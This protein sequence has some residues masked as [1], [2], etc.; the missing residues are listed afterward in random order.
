MTFGRLWAA[1]ICG[2]TALLF[3]LPVHSSPVSVFTYLPVS[4]VEN[5]VVQFDGSGSFDTVPT[6]SITLRV[7]DFG[8]NTPPAAAA[9]PLAQHTY[10]VAGA[11]TVGLTVLDEPGLIG[12]SSQTIVV[13]AATTPIPAALPLFA[14]GSGALGFVRLAEE[15]ESCR[16]L[17]SVCGCGRKCAGFFVVALNGPRGDCVF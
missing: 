5:Q 2:A 9:N 4:P 13:G 11:Y 16:R 12:F 10:L 6:L 8:D 7:W 3:S 17:I 1:A 15:T 14:T